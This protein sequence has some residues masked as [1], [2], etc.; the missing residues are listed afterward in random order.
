MFLIEV[1]VNPAVSGPLHGELAQLVST[2][3]EARAPGY[4][5]RVCV[6]WRDTDTSKDS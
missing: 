5:Q 3:L 1:D 4:A 6:S 2:A